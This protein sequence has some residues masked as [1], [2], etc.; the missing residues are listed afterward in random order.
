MTAPTTLRLRTST[1]D[2]NLFVLEP[3]DFRAYEKVLE[4]APNLTD[5]IKELKKR[6]SPWKK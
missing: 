4:A 3:E 6:P 2:H 1:E 5:I